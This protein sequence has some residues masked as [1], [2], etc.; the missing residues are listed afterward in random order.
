[1]ESLPIEV[2]HVIAATSEDAYR[3]LLAV[4]RLARSID[5]SAK[6]DY[7]I[8]F[9][10]RVDIGRGDITWTKNGKWHRTDGPAYENSV[11]VTSWW[12]ND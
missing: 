4:P 3:A 5:V 12:V 7:M 6:Y 2:L 10:Y 1:M 11:G 8:L 9:G